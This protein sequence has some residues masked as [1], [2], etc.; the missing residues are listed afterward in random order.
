MHIYFT[1]AQVPELA[2]FPPA[3]RRALRQTA[4]QQMFAA[5]PLLRWLP[6]GL[7]V[8][9]VLISLFTYGEL[10]RSLTAWGGHHTRMLIPTAHILLLAW[11]GGFIGAQALIR[12]SRTY[13]RHLIA[14]DGHESHKPT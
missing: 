14:S 11:L 4:F 8:V 12:C 3:T 7:C 10:P 1:D 5:R 2:P 13:L 9:G 6:G